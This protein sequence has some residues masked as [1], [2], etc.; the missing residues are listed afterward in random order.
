LEYKIQQN[1]EEI[2]KMKEERE[3]LRKNREEFIQAK[4]EE[5]AKLE[6]ATNDLSTRFNA[7]LQETLNKMK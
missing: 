1:T 4:N 2:S 6:Q 3:I 5:L 7:M